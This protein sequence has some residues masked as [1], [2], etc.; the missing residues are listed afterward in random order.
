MQK[1]L[2]ILI[3]LVLAFSSN[4][5]ITT[6]ED[7]IKS[8][9]EIIIFKDKKKSKIDFQKT[10]IA[11]ADLYPLDKNNAISRAIVYNI[12]G[13]TASDIY[14]EVN[15]WFVHSF[16]SGKSVIQL[17]EKEE[18]CIIGKGYIDALGSNGGFFNNSAG[19]AWIILRV[20]IRDEKMRVIA[21][22]QSYEV[23]K[24]TGI[25]A[26]LL[27]VPVQNYGVVEYIPSECFPY[28]KKEKGT[29]SKA[30]TLAHCWIISCFKQLNEAVNHGMTG[31]ETDDF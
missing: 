3:A 2:L 16:G 25:G 18:G 24:S 28:T 9:E 6:Y 20:D 15:N 22:I 11:L 13:K 31:L 19:A 5:Q 4:A 30:L 1:K 26:A 14:L 8:S 17:N 21:S 27:G 10:A 29:G 12:P 7:F 23:T